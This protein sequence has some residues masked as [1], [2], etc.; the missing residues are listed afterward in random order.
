LGEKTAPVSFVQTIDDY[1]ESFHS[2]SSPSRQH[3]IAGMASA[4]DDEVGDLVSRYC[5]VNRVAMQVVATIIWG[6]PESANK[7]GE[8]V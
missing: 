5:P 6:R 7:T 8:N 3:M 2:M 4:F 1:I